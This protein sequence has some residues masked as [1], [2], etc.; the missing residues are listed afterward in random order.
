MEDIANF[1]MSLPPTQYKPKFQR[2][3]TPTLP[4][5]PQKK[6]NPKTTIK[7]IQ[8][9]LYSHKSSGCKTVSHRQT[10]P[11]LYHTWVIV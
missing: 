3:G 5:P 9:K 8:N 2:T 11:I 6:T 7:K 4:P 10:T 1:L